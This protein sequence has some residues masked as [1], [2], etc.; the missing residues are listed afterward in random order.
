MS[1]WKWV[2]GEPGGQLVDLDD[3][4]HPRHPAIS[5]SG[6]FGYKR[7]KRN[8]KFLGDVIRWAIIE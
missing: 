8:S 3:P 5:R 2:P 1:R 7:K 4:Y 6:L